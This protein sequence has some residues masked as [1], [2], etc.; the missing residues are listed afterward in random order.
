MPSLEG[1]FRAACKAGTNP[2]D[3]WDMT[4]QE[5]V[6]IMEATRERDAEQWNHTSS[7]M[8]LYANSK[9]AKGKR[10]SPDDFHP[11]FI[12]EKEARKPKTKEDIENLINKHKSF[13]G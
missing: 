12:Q 5:N 1:L 10:F 4:L 8:A 13:N 3:F 2:V 7:L 6:L 11:M 9:S